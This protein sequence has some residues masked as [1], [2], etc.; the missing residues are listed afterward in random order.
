MS[1]GFTKLSL[2][3]AAWLVVLGIPYL[4]ITHWPL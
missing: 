3:L 1:K 2:A 4:I